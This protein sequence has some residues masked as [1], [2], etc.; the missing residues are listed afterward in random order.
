[1]SAAR[2]LL[3]GGTQPGTVWGCCLGT[4]GRDWTGRHAPV[5]APK[6]VLLVMSRLVS[7][8][9]P[10]G[11]VTTVILRVQAVEPSA[12][13]DRV[14]P[15]LAEQKI[16]ATPASYLVGAETRGDEV[17]PLA[18]KNH[19]ST[20]ATSYPVPTITADDEVIATLAIHD[21]CASAPTDHISL[22]GTCELV[23]LLRAHDR[24]SIICCSRRGGEGHGSG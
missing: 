4:L 11:D 16:S 5:A 18:A 2:L 24:A 7:S 6:H 19:I 14:A 21:V 20:R 8:T 3:A 1:M 23:L 10:S 13:K 12:S 9:T 15:L 17:R 22:G